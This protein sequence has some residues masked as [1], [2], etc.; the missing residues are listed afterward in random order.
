MI[1][2]HVNAIQM[3]SDAKFYEGYSRWDDQTGRYETWNES[4]ARVMNMH[5]EY[6]NGKITPE[7]ESLMQDAERLY[8]N[9]RILGAQ[10]ALQFGGDQLL[11]KNMKMYNCTSTY[12]DR[13]AFF[14]ELMWI[15][16]C[17]AGAGFSVQKH[18]VARLPD[19][20]ERKKQVKA[21]VVEDSIEGWADAVGVL[22]SS[23]FV[24]GGVFPDYEGRKI[25]FDLS[26]IRPQGALIS[27]GFKA[28][29]PEPLRRSLDKIEY[30]IQG[31]VLKGESRLRPIDVYDIS[32]HVADAV[33]AG[34][35]R[36]SATI[37]LFS[38]DDDEMMNAKTGNWFVENPQRARSNNTVLL[39]RDQVTKEQFAEIM[40]RTK[41]FGEPGFGFSDSTEFTFNPCYE[42]GMYP[43]D[44]N[45]ETGWQGC[46]LVETNGSA[47]STPEE[48][49]EACVSA[50]VLGTLQAGYTTFDYLT[51]AT[52]SIFERE[53]LLG[54]SIT[55]W[56]NNPEVLFDKSVLRKGARI[57]KEINKKVAA[58]I[59]INP[60]ARTT[61][62]KPSGN[63]S[64][65][66]MTASGITGE[67]APRYI[68]NAQMNKQ[69]EV[70]QLIKRTNP[71]MVEDSVWSDANSDYVVSFPIVANTNS[72]FKKDL[73][74]VN[75]LEKVK[76]A[77]SVWVEE[78]TDESLCVDPRV[79]HN[80]SNTV[81]VNTEEQWKEVEEYLFKNRKYFAGVSFLAGT[82]D[83]DYAQAPFTEVLTEEEILENYGTGALFGAGLVTDALRVF[84]T[85]WKAIATANNPDS[86]CKEALDQQSE[87]IRR[88]GRFADNY[89]NGDRKKAE[90]CLKD[91]ALLHKWVKINQHYSSINFSAELE[92]KRFTDVD[93]LGAATCYAGACEVAF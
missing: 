58:I 33:L 89:Y 92:A 70:V 29:G 41:E 49:Y 84:P 73:L 66:L 3:L 2:N 93:T 88:F 50:A 82:G 40:K 80:I 23:Y 17:G 16:L 7:L 85:L 21:Y 76:I 38:P 51:P 5:R 83:K 12:A 67:H 27:G 87:W 74:G 54:V 19:I 30:L 77:Q 46:N 9:K 59:G 6:Y 90:Y 47:C 52:K 34:G 65:L 31:R 56:M 36:R 86:S 44:A 15:L 45:G 35:V 91:L 64:V 11:R 43:V 53:A 10:R 20:Q 78:G 68:R 4:V 75:L 24:G 63:A 48:F 8:K 18:H 14:N 32:M 69:S 39:V 26:N 42:I 61:C 62:S 79:R 1:S 37:S 22:M 55:G 13:P 28:P 81:Q 25:Y 60:A 57:V 71:Y 72:I